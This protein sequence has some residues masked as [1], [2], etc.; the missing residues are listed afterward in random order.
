MNKDT[1][2]SVIKDSSKAD[3]AVSRKRNGDSYQPEIEYTNSPVEHV[4]HL[5]RTVGNAS[6]ARLIQSG[7]LQAKL[8]IGQPNDIYEREADHLADRVMRMSLDESNG[9]LAFKHGLDVESVQ[10]KAFDSQSGGI[11]P[12][13]ESSLNSFRGSGDPLSES[14]RS[15]FEP[16][17]GVDFGEVRVHTGARAAE[18]SQAIN[19][20]AFTMGNNIVFNRS[21][22]APGT[23][24][25][26]HLLAHE[27]THVVQQRGTGLRDIHNYSSDGTTIRRS[28]VRGP[29]NISNPVHEVLTLET[30]KRTIEELELVLKELP[31][32]NPENIS[33]IDNLLEMFSV[34]LEQYNAVDD[35]EKHELD[36]DVLDESLTDFIRGV[37]WPDDPKGYLFSDPYSLDFSTGTM[38]FEEF[39]AD[40]RDELEEIIARSHYGDLQFFHAMTDLGEDPME[41]RDRILKWSRFLIRVA[42]ETYGPEMK[43]S[44]IEFVRDLFTHPDHENWKVKRL[45]LFDGSEPAAEAEIGLRVRRR[46]SGALLHLVQDSYMEGHVKRDDDGNIIQFH[47][48][49]EQ[50]GDVHGESDK[51]G[52]EGQTLEERIANLP[53]ASQAIDKGIGLLRAIAFG[54]ETKAMAFIENNVLKLSE[55]TPPRLAGPGAEFTA[56]DTL[57]DLFSD[58]NKINE[59]LGGFTNLSQQETILLCEKLITAI[60]DPKGSDPEDFKKALLLILMTQ[61]DNVFQ[62]VLNM[63]LDEISLALKRDNLDDW[64]EFL[65]IC[66]HKTSKGSNVG[67]YRIK[68]EKN[69]NAARKLVFGADIWSKSISPV[70]INKLS[71]SEWAGVIIALLSG[72]TG[73]EDEQSILYILLRQSEG[74]FKETVDEVGGIEKIDGG[75]DW[76]EWDAFLLLCAHK[77]YPDTANPAK[78]I[79]AKNNDNAARM[80]LYGAPLTYVQIPAVGW[81]HLSESQ[82]REVIKVLNSGYTGD[83]DQAAIIA[84]NAYLR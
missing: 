60:M 43:I 79:I 66:S 76:E 37:F 21:S 31:E 84:I 9:G 34:K 30:I 41:T 50:V 23:S 73:E 20:R 68:T 38:W 36:V 46:A 40:E 63:M 24:G 52:E 7:V 29:W 61:E 10:S 6:V 74:G 19:A 39:D 5:Q 59:A 78:F 35:D 27:L 32:A 12:G 1:R 8:K 22:Y 18:T 55:K 26:D 28:E 42:R 62:I 4:M 49:M 56:P 75:I 64:E 16:R 57:V 77:K 45:F 48:Y 17:F 70:S 67:A 83:E 54:D 44:D 15:H 11:S 81:E 58:E 3:T 82:W 51:W 53:G 65:V 2:Q 80:L 47:S 14:T 71:N 72:S 25:G 69:D 13:L 33:R